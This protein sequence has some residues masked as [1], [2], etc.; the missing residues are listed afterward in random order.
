MRGSNFRF[1]ISSHIK[2]TFNPCPFR[3]T[4]FNQVIK[5]GADYLFMKNFPVPVIIDVEF[6]GFQ[7]YY[8]LP[9]YIFNVDCSEI[10]EITDRAKTCKFRNREI[11]N[12]ISLL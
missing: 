6:Q 4:N 8:F 12:V 9:G 10:R 1:D 11:D 3:F 2:I 5:Y 7:L